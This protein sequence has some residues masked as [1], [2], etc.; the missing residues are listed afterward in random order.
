MQTEYF[1][2]AE[3]A[4]YVKRGESSLAKMRCW[5][6]GPKYIKIGRSVRYRK[7]DLD[8]WMEE[9]LRLPCRMRLA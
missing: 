1:A 4:R 7:Q 9:G 8:A 2:P 3:A 5:G 6:G